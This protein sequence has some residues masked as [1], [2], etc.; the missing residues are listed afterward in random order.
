MDQE[1]SL[2]LL[3][4][5]KIRGLLADLAD[6]ED[7]RAG[8]MALS[9]SDDFEQVQQELARTQAALKILN[10]KGPLSMRGLR[11]VSDALKRLRVE[12]ALSIPELMDCAF[13]LRT[14]RRLRE[15]R[16]D[17]EALESVLD[18]EF[19][20]IV[21]HK[22]LEDRL[23]ASFNAEGEALD[24]ASDELYRIRRQIASAQSRVRESLDKLI[25]SAQYARCLQEPVV[26]V[27]GGRFV[28]PVKVEYKGEISGLV[29]DV[30]AT[31]A[32]VFIEPASVVEA[33]NEVRLLEGREKAEIEPGK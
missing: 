30:S 8:C 15:Y 27:R 28:V 22:A 29:H 12:A 25:R 24:T 33:N 1:K 32:T 23:Y 20:R 7:G 5:H 10:L 31:G 17:G 11:N 26:T 14:A 16:G 19:A 21:P 13:L 4:F 6:T 9:P 18:G 2:R 3:E